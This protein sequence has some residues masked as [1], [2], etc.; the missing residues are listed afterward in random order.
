M[1]SPKDRRPAKVPRTGRS[2]RVLLH[3]DRPYCPEGRAALEAVAVLSA[4]L[5]GRARIP[6]LKNLPGEGIDLEAHLVAVGKGLMQ[7]ALDRCD[8]VQ[9]EAG[10]LLHMT[11]RSF[12]YYAKK[13][14]LVRNSDGSRRSEP[15]EPIRP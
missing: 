7:E 5:R 3:S 12:R 14:G 1:K 15:T 9:T 6:D 2:R 13:Y 8:G 4:A 10:K 11:F